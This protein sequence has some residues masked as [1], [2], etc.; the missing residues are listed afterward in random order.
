MNWRGRLLFRQYIKNKRHKYGIK[1]NELCTND[2]IVLRVAIYG[3]KSFEDRENLGAKG[4]IVLHLVNHYLDKGYAYSLISGI[5]L[6]NLHA[7]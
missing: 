1:Q 3:G 6:C 4:A 7:T 5:T 2:G